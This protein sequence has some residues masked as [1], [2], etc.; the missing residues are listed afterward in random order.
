MD[1]YKSA[2]G[3]LGEEPFAEFVEAAMQAVADGKHL[4]TINFGEKD[5][6]PARARCLAE[7]VM[8]NLFCVGEGALMT[9]EM[10]TALTE[11]QLWRCK[12]G[13][14][15]A[16]HLARMLGMMKEK[17]FI[18]AVLNLIDNDVAVGGA[19]ALGA[20]LRGG[21]NCCLRALFLSHNPRIGSVGAA[22]LCEGLRTNTSLMELSME[23]CNIG[24]EGGRSIAQMLS[25]SGSHVK[26]IMLAGNSLG[27]KGLSLI[28]LGLKRNKTLQIL[29][30]TMNQIGNE[31]KTEE[32][33]LQDRGVIKALIQALKRNTTLTQLH[34]ESNNIGITGA[35]WLEPQLK[36][37]DLYAASAQVDPSTLRNSGLHEPKCPRVLASA[38]LSSYP[39]SPHLV[40]IRK[41]LGIK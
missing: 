29:D 8:G 25:F 38:L 30:L 24:V 10:Y 41:A 40:E 22:A 35:E 11:I 16:I 36:Q 31:Q 34:L 15:G 2:C 17:R 14:S 33:V 5:L 4:Q 39:P 20:A 3:L 19:T 26:K 12:V 13:D 32:E 7:A 9:G 27:T 18:L 23:H 6:G 28:T 1:H 37:L 21:C